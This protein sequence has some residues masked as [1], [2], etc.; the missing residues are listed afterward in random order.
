M[1]QAQGIEWSRY[2][3]QPPYADWRYH[4]TG[5]SGTRYFIEP[6]N[7]LTYAYVLRVNGKRHTRGYAS[8]AS[9]KAAARRMEAQAAPEAQAAREAEAQATR[10]AK[11]QAAREAMFAQSFP[12]P[13]GL[14]VTEGHA[15]YCAQHGH[16]T[17][18]EDGAD[19]GICPRCGEVTEAQAA[20]VETVAQRVEEA[21][22]GMCVHASWGTGRAVC[23][24]QY[25][26]AWVSAAS[27]REDVTCL[28]CLAAL[29]EIRPGQAFRYAGQRPACDVPAWMAAPVTFRRVIERGRWEVFTL[30]G[31]RYVASADLAAWED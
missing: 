26:H 11:A 28:D 31:T 15:R 10:E 2:S 4:G 9:A 7:G 13:N 8:V 1:A 30:D 24:N 6:G 17:W 12:V 18:Q 14:A 23:D 25:G 5:D 21:R 29:R 19:K 27:A 22:K 20:P 16:A 3:A